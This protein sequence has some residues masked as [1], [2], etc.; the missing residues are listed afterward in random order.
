MRSDVGWNLECD[1]GLDKLFC[2]EA[3]G[4][5]N[6]GSQVALFRALVFFSRETL[7]ILRWIKLLKGRGMAKRN[8]AVVSEGDGMW[9]IKGC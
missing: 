7:A 5:D 3:K 1:E 6:H 4:R 2:A 9:G 8:D